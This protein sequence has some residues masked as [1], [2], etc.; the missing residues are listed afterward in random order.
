TS[1]VPGP[2]NEAGQALAFDVIANN[3][4]GLFAVPPAISSN[5]TL[6]FTAAPGTSGLA[7]LTIRLRDDG[8]TA[9]GGRNTSGS[10]SLN[11]TVRPL[12]V[13][14][15]PTEAWVA[16]AY[17]DIL[18]RTVDSAGL[19]FWTQL[20]DEGQPRDVVAQA[21]MNSSEGRSRTVSQLYITLL[22]RP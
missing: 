8:G 10:Q 15:T 22:G 14:G 5:G 4:P 12:A 6:T 16:Q 13:K 11:I 21:L 7:T 17:H 2:P 3:N 20:L 9:N 18:G 19:V 1:I